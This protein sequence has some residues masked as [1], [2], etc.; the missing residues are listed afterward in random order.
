MTKKKKPEVPEAP[1]EVIIA[2]DTLGKDLVTFLLQELKAAQK[3]WQQMSESEQNTVIDRAKCRIDQAVTT[4]IAILFGNGCV[5][6]IADI[7][8]VAIKDNVKCILK[9]SRTNSS[10]AMHELFT[11]HN[12][13]C[14]ILLATPDAYLGGMDEIKGEADQTSLPLDIDASVDDPLTDDAIKFCRETN[15]ASISGLQ[16]YLKIAYN[17]ASKIIVSLEDKGIISSPDGKG[18]RTVFPIPE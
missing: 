14:R 17:R 2:S 5:S 13:P 4:A 15:K 10:E 12:Q 7:E 3:P 16:R 18:T 11:A 1:P 6:V 9:V 8:G